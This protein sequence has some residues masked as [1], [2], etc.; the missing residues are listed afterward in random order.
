MNKQKKSLEEATVEEEKRLS[1]RGKIADFLSGITYS[2]VV[3]SLLDYSAGLRFPG[4]MYSRASSLVTDSLTSAPYGMWRDKVFKT[5]KT[6]EKSGKI[7]KYL[8]DLVAFNTFQIPVYAAIVSFASLLSDG[9]YIDGEKVRHGVTYL[10]AISPLIAPTRGLYMDGVRK[11]FGVKSS[12]EKAT[13]QKEI[14]SKKQ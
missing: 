12:L 1:K 11:L 7:K 10:A 4:I 8:T 6:T 9:G 14:D 13:V 3:G 5:A 2:L